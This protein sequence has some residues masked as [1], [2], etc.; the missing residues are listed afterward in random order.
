ML[1][2]VAIP[3][4][5]T[6]KMVITFTKFEEMESS[7]V[8]ATPTCSADERYGHERPHFGSWFS[9]IKGSETNVPIGTPK[10]EGEERATCLPFHVIMCGPAR[11]RK[12]EAHGNEKKKFVEQV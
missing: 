3:L 7:E 11:R 2:Q 1:G 6:V 9:W 4:I 8:F 12:E 5:P 10:L